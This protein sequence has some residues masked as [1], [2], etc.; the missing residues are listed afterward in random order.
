[1]WTGGRNLRTVTLPFCL[2]GKT[3]DYRS[4]RVPVHLILCQITRENSQRQDDSHELSIGI[5]LNFLMTSVLDRVKS[6]VTK[7]TR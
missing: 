5:A 4:H 6:M 7:R 3:A 2:A 1:M